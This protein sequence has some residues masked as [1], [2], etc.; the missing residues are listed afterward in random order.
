MALRDRKRAWALQIA[1]VGEK[2]AVNSQACCE[3]LVER[4]RQTSGCFPLYELLW[5]TEL[6]AGTEERRGQI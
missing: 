2:K 3:Q 1:K 6:L 5:Y 4:P